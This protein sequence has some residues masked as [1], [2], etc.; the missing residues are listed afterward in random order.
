MTDPNPQSILDSVKKTLGLAPDYTTFDLDI[1]LFINSAFGSLQQLGVGPDDGFII[2]DNTTLWSQY[3][4]AVTYLGMVQSYIFMSVRLAFDPPPTSFA[5]DAIQKQTVELGWRILVA[6][7]QITPPSN[8]FWDTRP[9]VGNIMSTY[10][11]VRVV[12]LVFGDV[13]TI[14]ASKGNI[15]YLTM[16]ADCTINAP[17]TGID[18]EHITLEVTSGGFNA[19]WG[20]GWNFGDAGNPTLSSDG[21]TDI[22]S[23]YYRASTTDWRAGFTRGF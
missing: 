22:V 18:G 4:S 15:F 3:I 21:K 12:N 11:A 8:P 2:Q 9:G 5:I 19:T 23:A 7:E 17:V 10:F 13:V 6:V 1:V 16:T 14:D 20:S